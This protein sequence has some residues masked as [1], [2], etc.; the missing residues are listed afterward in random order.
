MPDAPRI[1]DQV[2]AAIGIGEGAGCARGDHLGRPPAVR[3]PCSRAAPDHRP[4][5]PP[6]GRAHLPRPDR[7]P[8]RL[9]PRGAN[10]DRLPR[11]AG[12]PRPS[13]RRGSSLGATRVMLEPLSAQE[14]EE[15]LE[16]LR[17]ETEVSP[18][19]LGRITEAAE[20]NPLF[21]EQLLAM[22]TEN[23]ARDGRARDPAVDPRAPRC[24]ARPPSAGRAR[25]DRGRIGDRQG[26]LARRRLRPSRR[27]G[28]RL[29]RRQPHDPRAEGAH[30]AGALDL[31]AED[32]FQFRHILIRD[33]AYLGVPKETRA[34]LHERY[35]DWLE[36]TTGE[37]AS[38]LDEIVG[39]HLEQ[40][41]RTGR[42][43]AS[44][45]GRLRARDAGR[46]AAG[47]R[48]PSS[49]RCPRRRLR[50]RKPRLACRRAPPAGSSEP[51]QLLVELGSAL[52]MT[53]DFTRAGDV[54]NEALAIAETTGDAQLEAR[55]LIEREFHKVFA[56]P[57]D[58]S[59]D[60]PRG[61]RTRG[62]RFS[63]RRATTSALRGRGGCGARSPFAPATGEPA[64]RRSSEPSS[65]HGWRGT[66][67]SRRRWW[68]CSRCPS[69]TARRQWKR[70]SSAAKR[71]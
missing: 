39:Y 47:G 25:G 45:R 23:G 54:L 70:R 38:E 65:T 22:I 51:G 57:E 42:S 19:L 71:S 4:G 1:A 48:R 62:F 10:P 53:G 18:D 63:S 15:L 20:G 69:T 2:A 17:G 9:E 36:R 12:P 43:S 26:V 44:R 8:R 35:A 61:D 16:H 49:N 50:H 27:R 5:R 13:S 64:P 33:A 3:A 60:H 31:S 58:A 32:G 37:R 7:V 34:E 24:A 40:A 52:M 11:A 56:G 29:R 55:A 67:G 66:C 14:A 59:R 41:F 30:R 6:V 46:R 21:V 28:P 68:L